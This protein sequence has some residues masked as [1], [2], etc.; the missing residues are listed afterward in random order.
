MLSEADYIL[1]ALRESYDAL[2]WTTT[3]PAQGSGEEENTLVRAK[4]DTLAF[5]V[6]MLRMVQSDGVKQGLRRLMGDQ[7]ER[8]NGAGSVKD[9]GA[10][11]VSLLGGSLADAVQQAESGI[12]DEATSGALRNQR[13]KLAKDDPVC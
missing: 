1:P 4:S 6:E 9:G 8:S 7:N 5:C 2:P 3:T 13:D 11:G 12:V 10:E